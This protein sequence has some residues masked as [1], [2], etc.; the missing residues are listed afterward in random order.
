[1]LS[2]AHFCNTPFPLLTTFWC[3]TGRFFFSFCFL[4]CWKGCFECWLW[5]DIELKHN[6]ALSFGKQYLISAQQIHSIAP[7]FGGCTLHF[8]R[9]HFC[10][11]GSGSL[12]GHRSLS[13]ADIYS[14]IF[15][16]FI[17][18][19][20][21]FIVHAPW[22]TSPLSLNF[23]KSNEMLF[24]IL[25]CLWIAGVMCVHSFF[26]FVKNVCVKCAGVFATRKWLQFNVI[27][28]R[29]QSSKIL[30]PLFYACDDTLRLSFLLNP[31]CGFKLK[32]EKWEPSWW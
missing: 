27:Y 20:E 26:F 19:E 29:Y 6:K 3:W 12:S 15:W 14:K 31:T 8:T 9:K 16:P 5:T 23:C 28:S 11:R 4:I 22:S 32:Y 18:L 30:F 17:S 1:M 13:S 24:C 25:L 10:K 2:L 21:C 7:Q